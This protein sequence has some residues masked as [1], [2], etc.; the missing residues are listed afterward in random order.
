MLLSGVVALMD[1]FN[2]TVPAPVLSCFWFLKLHS[3]LLTEWL[4]VAILH[5]GND[6][7]TIAMLND[8]IAF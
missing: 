1:K 4:R 5:A 2:L 6:V 3:S 8:P 7:G